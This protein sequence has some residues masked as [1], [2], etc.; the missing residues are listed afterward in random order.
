MASVHGADVPLVGRTAE[1][2]RVGGLLDEAAA[3][4]SGA[5]VLQG[6]AGI[7]KTTL[8]DAAASLARGRGLT[9]LRARALQAEQ[10]LAFAG[11]RE[12]LAP[13]L[14][15]LP[16]LDAHHAV[17]LEVA[18]GVRE[19][20]PQPPFAV[21]VAL[22]ALLAAAE[23]DGLLVLLDDVQWLDEGSFEAVVFAVRRLHADGV[24]VLMATRPEPDR[25]LRERGIPHL[26]LDGLSPE[27]ARTLAGRA[28]GEL[29][30]TPLEQL[31]GAVDGHP[32]ALVELAR[33]LT[34][35]Q[36][37]GVAPLAEP[38]RP[39]PAIER[40]FRGRLDALPAQT[41]DALAVAAA[42]EHA[43]RAETADAIRRL[44]IPG[45]A[46]DAAERA[47]V[48]ARDGVRWRFLHPLLRATAYHRAGDDLRRDAHRALAEDAEP[49][50]R[51]WHR[52]AAAGQPDE[53]VAAELERTAGAVTRRGALASAAELLATAAEL[54]PDAPDRGRRR[55]AAATIL[56]AIG[57][58]G[59]A[60]PLVEAALAEGPT[61]PLLR[62]DLERVRGMTLARGGRLDDGLRIVHDAAE[63][64]APHDPARAAEMLL[65]TAPGHWMPG[66]FDRMAHVADRVAELTAPPNP[67]L[68]AHADVAGLVRALVLALTGRPA[69]AAA[70]LDRHAGVLERTDLPDA[71]A[72]MLSTP[73]HVAVWIER[74]DLAQRIMTR[75]LEAARARRAPGE[76][77]YPLAV[78]G[79]LGLRTGRLG[80][81]RAAG[82]EAFALAQDANLPVLLAPTGGLLAHTEAALGLEAECREHA[83]TSLA[84][85]DLVGGTSMGLSARSAL[86]LLALGLG[87]PEEALPPL[88]RCAEDSA[89]I[90]MREPNK[91]RFHANLV[92]ALVLVGDDAGAREALEAFSRAAEA[93]PSAWSRA[94]VLRSRGLV[95]DGIDGAQHLEAS[96]ALLDERG[97]AFEAAR[98]RLL[99][100]ERLRRVRQRTRARGP[101][102][103]ALDAFE[104]MGAATWAARAR[105]ELRATGGSV[106]GEQHAAEE[107]LAPHELRVA[108]LVADGRTN[109]EVASELFMSRK[110]V[111]HH[112][113]QIYRKLGLR[114]RTE[115]ARV[116][117][118]PAG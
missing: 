4:H 14:G 118:R 69:E 117:A 29:A 17:A 36:R 78:Q 5:L 103:D 12:L 65:S 70:A 40:A 21:S 10:G 64:V 61:D 82:S 16:R 42:D 76:L 80:P 33:A 50:R 60:L 89:R 46:L 71:G 53:D 94:A 96:A 106:G 48:L 109:P 100:G 79:E 20:A 54:S 116:L 115:L 32:L 81:A 68:P 13:A 35:E 63:A 2:R 113:S 93:A 44:G 51:A 47:G 25:G 49:E 22:L 19:G 41:A 43:S 38:L 37:A 86:G 99:L 92:E 31:V 102:Q 23:E 62:S 8:L 104:R 1:L 97:D 15:L 95:A 56:T 107:R 3:G 73:A 67:A 75:Q 18:L 30:A 66:H 108:L 112:L 83:A 74:P 105:D 34:P 87:R 77:I 110:T 11:L 55:A 59:R 9:V 90:G 24:A 111:E 98:S 6:V 58:P 45:D 85:C 39:G 91:V 84:I 88:R 72:E 101:L 26:D 7:G 57:D 114:S 28:A 52:A 27:E